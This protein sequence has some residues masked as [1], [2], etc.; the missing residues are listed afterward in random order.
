MFR[1]D[2][3]VGLQTMLFMTIAEFGGCIPGRSHREPQRRHWSLADLTKQILDF[4]SSL[5]S[6]TAVGASRFDFHLSLRDPYQR[7]WISSSDPRFRPN[8]A[9]SHNSQPRQRK[10]HILSTYPSATRYSH[11]Y[12][13]YHPQLRSRLLTTY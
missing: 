1:R 8:T 12:N 2:D 6:Y 3:C 10:T 11:E 5:D 9:I 7:S 4:D 13:P